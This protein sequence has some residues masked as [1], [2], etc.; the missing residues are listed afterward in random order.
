MNLKV[1]KRRF[2]L[3]AL[4][5][6][7][8]LVVLSGLI[9]SFQWINKPF[10]GFFLYS[11]LVVGP[12]FLPQWS[13]GR[14]G[15]SFLDHVVAVEDRPVVNRQE[16]YELVRSSPV[17][18]PFRYTVERAGKSFSIIVHSMKFSFFDWLLSYGIYLLVGLGFFIIGI[19][20][21]TLG[22]SSP[23]AVPLFFMASSVFIWFSTTFNYMTTG[24]F[25]NEVRII[26][27]TL[28]PSAGIHLGLVLTR[29]CGEARRLKL[30][31]CLI[32]AV[33]IGLA[34]FYSST[35]YSSTSVWHWA[36][37]LSYA[38][39]WIAAII[40]LGMIWITL[41][42]PQSDLERSRLRV[43][44]GGA[45]L[46]FFLPTLGTVIG[47]S[48]SWNIPHNILLIF[49]V[50]FPL[51][52]AFA[53]LKYNLFDIDAIFKLGLQATITGGLLLVY[54]LLVVVLSMSVGIYEKDLLIPLFFSIL[55]VLVFSPLLRWI[56]AVVSRYVYRRGYDPVLL[57]SEVSAL[58]RTL[59]KPQS[60]AEKYLKTVKD[61]VGIDSAGV[62]CQ[63]AEPGKEFAVSVNGDPN[64]YS[65]YPLDLCS[66]WIENF[67][68]RDKG[69]SKD[70]ME[71]NPLYR[72]DRNRLLKIFREC[73]LEL[74]L[75]MIFE[76]QLLGLVSLGKKTTGGGYSA[77]DLRLLSNLTE[78]L[79][80][81]LKNGMLYE[82][83]EKAKD[84]YEL[85]YGESEK[86]NNR[87]REMDQQKKHFVANV[88]H[89]LRTPISTILG[90]TELLLDPAYD[91][92]TRVILERIVDG[93]QNVSELMDSLLEFSRTETGTMSLSLREVSMRELFDTL[94]TMTLR[95]VKGRPIRFRWQ[96]DPAVAA[97]NTDPKKLQQILMH[98]LTN[99]VKFTEK[100]EIALEVKPYGASAD[101]IVEI[102]VSDTGVG[103]NKG[104]QEIIFDEFRQLDGSST[105]QY[106]GTGL[107]LSL[108]KKLAQ[109]LGGRIDVQSKLG[110]GSTFSLILP[111]N[112][113]QELQSAALEEL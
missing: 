20:P 74:L 39:S 42:N 72:N 61:Q 82:E 78:Q 93:G 14:E 64:R 91:G 17:N 111:A 96:I 107:G 69:I 27:F 53:L 30:Y 109:S 80:L 57:Q 58:L 100:G 101:D 43:V 38:Y 113:S 24:V 31:L 10:P 29:I 104:D 48:L 68:S 3:A 85:L 110:I 81:S 98:L 49:T 5:S 112:G 99:A 22:S 45:I 26:S 62:V 37:R 19:V 1:W 60:I 40:F 71:A 7:A 32:Y 106:G 4:G 88:S 15:L 47:S 36:V 102:A 66:A 73:K 23:S 2:L 9:P 13:G 77:D 105:R 63:Y 94:E 11:N 54:V 75:P 67:E 65:E 97:M 59:S 108:C 56:E 50:F 90:Y 87:L 16:I 70:E 76:K 92:E 18:S 12:D 89:E 33:S 95:L 52:V 25:P 84:K 41:R 35:F 83:S 28:V 21:I 8:F 55:V 86:M 79:A 44:F 46:G 51:S 34:L 6:L 103:I